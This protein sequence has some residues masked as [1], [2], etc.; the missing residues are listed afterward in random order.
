MM[1]RMPGMQKEECRLNLAF[2]PD[3]KVAVVH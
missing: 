2:K 3:A 1:K